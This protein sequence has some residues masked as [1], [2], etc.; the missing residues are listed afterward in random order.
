MKLI[1]REFI[2]PATLVVW[3]SGCYST[4]DSERDSFD[5]W[6]SNG[7]GLDSFGKTPSSDCGPLR[8]D[9]IADNN[10]N[11][12]PDNQ[13]S[14]C[15]CD[16][17][18]TPTGTCNE[19][20]GY[21]GFGLCR[22]GERQCIATG[23]TS[24]WSVCVGD[25]GPSIEACNPTAPDSN[26]TGISGD[27]VGCLRTLT[28]YS[29]LEFAACNSGSGDVQNLDYASAGQMFAGTASPGVEWVAFSS[30]QVFTTWAQGLVPIHNCRTNLY[31]TDDSYQYVQIG[32]SCAGV[33]PYLDGED[34]GIVGYVSATS[35]PGYLP[36]SQVL[37]RAVYYGSG[38]FVPLAYTPV[39]GCP[40]SCGCA[41]TNFHVIP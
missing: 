37:L 24:N 5:D 17:I 20:P 40:V 16:P 36:L 35:A 23:E 4:F 10:C 9:S 3:F 39:L 33:D 13:E 14:T 28:I 27:G 12:I 29:Q 32:D 26:C 25:I 31:W 6:S 8:C 19:H 18:A 21:D 34:L 1:R 41:I 30:F 22:A 2:V 11:Q 15:S 38:G 7:T